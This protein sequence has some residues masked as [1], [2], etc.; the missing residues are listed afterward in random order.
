MNLYDKRF[1]YFEWD[2]KLDGKEGFVADDI[3]ELTNCVLG[4]D[5][6]YTKVRKGPSTAYPFKD[7]TNNNDWVFFYYDPKYEVKR[8]YTE[9]EK[10]QYKFPEWKQWRNISDA[11]REDIEKKGLSWFDDDV[12]YRINPEEPEVRPFEDINELMNITETS[13][14]WV[15]DKRTGNEFL[16]TGT[17]KHAV[18]IADRWYNM[19]ELFEHYTFSDGS[20]CGTRDK[21]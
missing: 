18:Y 2:D 21:E 10:I 19:N 12:E 1:V 16:I 13:L 7:T 11:D 6:H 8:A 4:G 5:F 20:P 15:V 14:I 3:C 9:G 17:Q